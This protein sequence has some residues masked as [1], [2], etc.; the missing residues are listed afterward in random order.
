MLAAISVI[1]FPYMQVLTASKLFEK[2][3]R[4][5]NAEEEEEEKGGQ[6]SKGALALSA[7]S[8]GSLP[9]ALLTD[10]NLATDQI[11]MALNIQDTAPRENV[12]LPKRSLC[13]MSRYLDR[14][15][16]PETAARPVRSFEATVRQLDDFMAM[17]ALI[18]D[19]RSNP[20]AVDT[21][22]VTSLVATR[23]R[24]SRHEDNKHS[25]FENA[26]R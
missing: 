3:S 20:E 19:A 4:P 7:F 12:P 14:P 21:P 5:K 2:S 15:S 25:F 23:N 18:R 8:P 26:S 1:I 13:Y 17:K 22:V 9:S 11:P 10:N 6:S 24:A 16:G